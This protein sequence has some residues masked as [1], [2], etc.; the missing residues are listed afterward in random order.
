MSKEVK[1]KNNKWTGKVRFR[2][3]KWEKKVL[4]DELTISG[5]YS[6]SWERE[7]VCL[8]IKNLRKFV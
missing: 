5:G 6:D 2:N 3:K 1:K 4:D 7:C 8:S